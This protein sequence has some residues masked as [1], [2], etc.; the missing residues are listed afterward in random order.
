MSVFIV[1]LIRMWV[2]SLFLIDKCPQ[3]SWSRRG[4]DLVSFGWRVATKCASYDSRLMPLLDKS[5]Q[6]CLF[7]HLEWVQ[8][9]Q[10]R[11]VSRNSWS[12][13]WLCSRIAT[14]SACYC[15]ADFMRYLEWIHLAHSLQTHR[16]AHSIHWSNYLFT[17]GLC[18]F[19]LKSLVSR[20]WYRKKEASKLP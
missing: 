12:V 16:W 13:Q 8:G 19:Q 7:L 10:N 11:V 1:F 20:V 14:G 2:D 3:C 15:F 9:G 4:M 18:I 17:C 5:L 6:T